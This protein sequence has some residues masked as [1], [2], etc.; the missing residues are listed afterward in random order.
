MFKWIEQ[1]KL[2]K[3]LERYLPSDL[4]NDSMEYQSSTNDLKKEQIEFILVAL[5]DNSLD[6]CVE[7]IAIVSDIAIK[8]G[9]MV[10]GTVSNTVL[11]TAGTWPNSPKNVSIR[12]DVVSE[13]H[14]SLEQNIK[15]V[16][17]TDI[18]NVGMFGS[19]SSVSWGVLFPS[20]LQAMESLVKI[21]YGDTV[22][23]GT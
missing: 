15:T 16:H 20:Y 3:S 14:G 17:G 7:S 8:N 11:L 13:L 1:W 9:W 6:V 21:N 23:I 10:I 19:A 4:V 12:S 22:E 5:V 2:R 18:G